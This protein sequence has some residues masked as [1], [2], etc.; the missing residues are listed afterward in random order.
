M[1]LPGV[2][3]AKNVSRM[4][5][6][7]ILGG[8]LILGYHRVAYVQKDPYEVCVSP[9]NFAEQL[10]ALR[11]FAS[12]VSL[13][14]LVQQL[15]EGSLPPKTV[16]ITFDDGYEDNFTVAKPLLEK[17]EIP[18]TVFVCNGCAG[19]EFWWDELERL[20]LNSRADLQLLRLEA[21]DGRFQWDPPDGSPD[22]DPSQGSL[23]RRKFLRDLYHFLLPLDVDHL[24]QTMD[25]IRTWSG[26][27]S[28]EIPVSRAMTSQELLQISG[29]G[30]VEIGSH[31]RNH[32]MLPRLSPDRQEYE[33]VSSKQELEELLGKPVTGFAYPNGRSS[34]DTRRIVQTSGFTYACTS[35]ENVVR[36]GSEIYELP[37]LWQQDVDGDRFIST[38]NLWRKIR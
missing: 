27:P 10:E 3:T 29:D 20:V 1:R 15:K 37:R 7:R 22:P 17:H 4:L 30:L 16:A 19:S 28:G 31:T 9:E 14:Q 2:K 24:H 23:L 38:L 34:E 21:D 35:L 18:A 32:L 26:L 13:S 5:Q 8:A 11:K 6:A 25:S 12:P 36:P 33:I